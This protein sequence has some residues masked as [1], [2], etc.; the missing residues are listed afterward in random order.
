ALNTEKFITINGQKFYRSGDRVRPLPDGRLE[1]LGR[2]DRQ[3]KLRGQLIEPDEIE[4][5]LHNHPAIRHAAVLKT[6]AQKLVA[7]I[8][9]AQDIDE[10]RLQD[11]IAAHL[12]VWMVPDS[13]H[14][15]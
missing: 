7:Y 4:V 14:I 13:I 15:L 9:T 5:C 1:F 8:V 10:K 11:H 6:T 12:P 2:I 3:F